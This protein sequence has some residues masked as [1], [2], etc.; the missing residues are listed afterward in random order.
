[1][2]TIPTFY[3]DPSTPF[4]LNQNIN[5]GYFVEYLLSRPDV[6]DVWKRFVYHPFVMA[7]GNGT[8]P[9]D[10]FKGYIVQDYLYLVTYSLFSNQNQYAIMMAETCYRF[11]SREPTP[12]PRTRHRT[13]PTS[14]GYVVHHITKRYK[15]PTQLMNAI[16]RQPKLWH[17]SCTSSNFTLA[18]ANLSTSPSPRWK[19]PKNTKV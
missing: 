18:T 14:R 16:Y 12:W 5:R 13:F 11:T 3:Y 8:L 17:T 4:D 1:M 15:F 19:P 2:S 9:L 6:R 7:M 10:S